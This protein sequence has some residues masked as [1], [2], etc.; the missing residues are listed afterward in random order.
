MTIY[1]TPFGEFHLGKSRQ[2]VFTLFTLERIREFSISLD[3][4]RY[5]STYIDHHQSRDICIKILTFDVRH[6]ANCKL[7]GLCKFY[8]IRINFLP[9]AQCTRA[10]DV[11]SLPAPA[12]LENLRKYWPDM[13]GLGADGPQLFSPAELDASRSVKG[14]EDALRFHVICVSTILRGQSSSQYSARAFF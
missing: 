8:I 6:V 7:A 11:K 1:L 9:T 12:P 13:R 5:E 4:T 2:F 3:F 10:Y 14:G